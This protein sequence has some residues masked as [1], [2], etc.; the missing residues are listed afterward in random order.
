[1]IR[2]ILRFSFYGPDYTSTLNLVFEFS[3]LNPI[4]DNPIIGGINGPSYECSGFSCTAADERFVDGGFA[5]AT[6]LPAA[7]PLFAGGL[8]FVGYLALHR[9]RNRE[10]IP[11]A[12]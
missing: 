2:T 7:L 8:G 10:Q 4:A 6:P 9:K 3:L 5:T 12:A 1:V 11:A